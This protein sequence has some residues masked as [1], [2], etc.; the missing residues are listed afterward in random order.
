MT[1]SRTHKARCPPVT[2]KAAVRCATLTT[3][4]EGS[5]VFSRELA[6]TLAAI[7]VRGADE[8]YS[9]TVGAKIVA[10]S[11]AQNGSITDAAL[12]T[13]TKYFSGWLKASSS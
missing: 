9:G 11:Q 5:T 10:Y 12:A 1:A 13:R 2:P 3:K 6:E 4:A 8:A 7:R